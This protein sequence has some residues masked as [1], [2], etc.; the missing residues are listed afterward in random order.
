MPRSTHD[1]HLQTALCIFHS[2]FLHSW[3][4]RP[5][6]LSLSLLLGV[7]EAQL[8]SISLTWP[9]ERMRHTR[10]PLSVTTAIQRSFSFPLFIVDSLLLRLTDPLGHLHSPSVNICLPWTRISMRIT[11][12]QRA[13]AT[14][15]ASTKTMRTTSNERAR[16]RWT[17]D[18]CWLR[19]SRERRLTRHTVEVFPGD[20]GAIIGRQGK[21]IQML[22]TK[23]K[24]IIQVPVSRSIRPFI[25]EGSL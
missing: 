12:E 24:T 25:Y 19:V 10:S 20:A 7:R 21:N 11:N 2:R 13:T 14:A 6:D 1:F 18:S 4:A 23:Y 5:S 22:R 8:M 16:P 17:F 3:P 15:A 9:E